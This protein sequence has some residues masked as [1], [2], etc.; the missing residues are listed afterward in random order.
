MGA[1]S[2]FWKL[3]L[4]CKGCIGREN[5]QEVTWVVHFVEMIEN[6]GGVPV[7]IKGLVETGI[8]KGIPS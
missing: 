8:Q 6:Y 5:T 4:F 3:T 2:F 1:S 7:H